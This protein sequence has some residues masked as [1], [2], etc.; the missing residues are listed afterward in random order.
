M[1]PARLGLDEVKIYPNP[2]NGFVYLD[3]KV[4]VEIYNNIGVL[5]LKKETNLVDLSS[6]DNGIYNII[7]I[8]KNK[9]QRNKIVK[10]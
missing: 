7:T 3:R 10:Q 2:T 6:F 5:I 1:P 4:K 8:F 9:K